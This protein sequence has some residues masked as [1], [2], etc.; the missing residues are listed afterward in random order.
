VEGQKQ[1]LGA[2]SAAVGDIN[3]YKRAMQAIAPDSPVIAMAGIHQAQRHT[4][5]D[6]RDVADLM[7]R[8]QAILF[9]NT[10][11]DGKGHEG[12]RALLK[13]PEEK[14]LLS[15]F[16]TAAGDAFKGHEQ[17]ADL[18]Y[19]GAKAIYAARSAEEGDFSG[20]YDAKRWRAAIQLATGGVQSHNGSKIVLP[21]GMGY[22]TFQSTLADRTAQAAKATPPLNATVPEL[23]RLPLENF[24]DGR[25]LFRRGAGYVVDHNGRPLIVDVNPRAGGAVGRVAVGVVR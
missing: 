16:N 4:M 6:G 23:L 7:L 8:G 20:A 15:D 9:P 24:G 25:Y 19:Q 22:D 1:L 13:M 21:Y 5:T 18:F 17:A 11:E 10:K 14:L 2:L 3:L 12:G